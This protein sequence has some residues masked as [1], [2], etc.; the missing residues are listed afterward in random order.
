MRLA[1]PPSGRY[2][3][4]FNYLKLYRPTFTFHCYNIYVLDKIKK[5]PKNYYLQELKDVRVVGLVVFGVIV[6]LVSWSGLRTIETNYKLQQQIAR[7]EQ[8]NQLS[9]LK[10]SNLELSNQYYNTDQYLELQARRLF[11]KG[12]PGEKLLLVPKSVALAH[13]VEIPEANK[14]EAPAQSSKPGYQRNFEAWMSFFFHRPLE[15]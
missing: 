6:L 13:T 7:L 11:S 12:A 5:L 3:S 8:Q 15:E 10:N 4:F 2:G 1:R 14:P 9:E